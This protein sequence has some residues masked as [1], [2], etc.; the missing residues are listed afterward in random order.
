MA[1]KKH[2]ITCMVHIQINLFIP[3]LLLG[4]HYCPLC[5]AQATQFGQFQF[6]GLIESSSNMFKTQHQAYRSSRPTLLKICCCCRNSIELRRTIWCDHLYRTYT[7]F[8]CCFNASNSV[9]VFPT[10][11]M[12]HLLIWPT[13]TYWKCP[14]KLGK[15]DLGLTGPSRIFTSG[16]IWWHRV[17][18]YRP[19]V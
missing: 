14:P 17:W 2:I 12:R 15:I 19:H 10:I 8:F 1:F 16:C 4:L 3:V 9:G 7:S 6:D 13:K 5:I 18:F 11:C